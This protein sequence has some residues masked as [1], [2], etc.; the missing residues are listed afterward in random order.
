MIFVFMYTVQTSGAHIIVRIT[1]NSFFLSGDNMSCVHFSAYRR[2]TLTLRLSFLISTL[3]STWACEARQSIS[4]SST[5][6]ELSALLPFAN[7][8]Y[9]L[10]LFRFQSF[11]IS[12]TS[13]PNCS[14]G[15]FGCAHVAYVLVYI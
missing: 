9:T 14:F 7:L 8:P 12:F 5:A 1:L 4:S 2:D 13:V 10:I 6:D 11:S 3:S 15:P